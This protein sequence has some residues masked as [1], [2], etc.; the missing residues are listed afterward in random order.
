MWD[1]KVQA[2]QDDCDLLAVLSGEDVVEE[3]GFACAKVACSLKV[4]VDAMGSCKE[5]CTPVTIVIGTFLLTS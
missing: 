5:H 2:V 4:S 1:G 3:G